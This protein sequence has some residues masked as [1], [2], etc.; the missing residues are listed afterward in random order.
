MTIDIPFTLYLFKPF[1]AKVL[2]SLLLYTRLL[3]VIITYIIKSRYT[4]L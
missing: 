3:A 4:T 1:Y 2:K